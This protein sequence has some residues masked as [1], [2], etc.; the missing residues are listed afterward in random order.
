MRIEFDVSRDVDAAA[1]DVRDRVA[2]ITT[3]LPQD[4]DAPQIIKADAGGDPVVTLGF[5]SDSMS[6]LE[7]TDYSERNLVDRLSTVPGVARV[8]I[9]GARRYSMRIWI[10]RQALAARQLTV[11]DLEDALHRENIE[12]PAGRLESRTREFSLRTMVGLETEQDFRNL[13]I[14]RGTDGHLVRLD[15]VADVQLAAEND[16][17]YTRINRRPG[18]FLQVE[19]QSKGNTLEIVRGVRAEVER[20]QPSLPPGSRLEVSVDNAIPIEAA[21]REV[22]VAVGFALASVLCVIYLFLGNVRTT[23]VPAVTIPVSI[24]AALTVMYALGYSINV[25]TLLG[26]VLAIGLVVDDAIVVLENVHRRTELGEP[27]LVAAIT[28]TREIGF[29]VIATTLTLDLRVRADLVLAGRPRPAVPRVRLHARGVRRVLGARRAVAHA[30]ARVA[31]CRTTRG[32]AGFAHAVDRAFRALAGF[33]ERTLRRIIAHPWAV[34]MVLVA[35]VVAGVW[36]FT[37]LPS[38]F[39]P[40][41]D[42][43][44]GFIGIEA[45]EGSSFNYMDALRAATRGHPRQGDGEGRHRAH[46]DPR[47]GSGRLGL[48]H[49]RRKHRSRHRDHEAVARARAHRRWTCRARS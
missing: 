15:E 18:L 48:A 17:T 13:V 3:Q 33:Y 40:T 4:A 37:R 35:V 32:R 11:T 39:A 20:L 22:L 41:A 14:A 2:R 34:L 43:G 49:R 27:S 36:T 12:L 7:L 16:R 44:R 19:A 38:E 47:A 46:A 26:L 24:V 45:P 5:S 28:G 29:A 8:T 30:D 1:N 23:L 9:N 10:D 25:L 21:L 6:M 31:A 42:V